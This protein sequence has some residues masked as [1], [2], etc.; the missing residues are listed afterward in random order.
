MSRIRSLLLLSIV[1]AVC[2]VCSGAAHGN[3]R[4]G[5]AGHAHSL[6]RHA[7]SVTAFEKEVLWTLETL[8]G[9]DRFALYR[10]YNHLMSAWAQ[11]AVSQALLEL[12]IAS[13]WP[14]DEQ[15]LRMTLR[16]QAQFALQDLDETRQGLE[17]DMLDIA[18]ADHRRI[19]EAARSLLVEM[20]VTLD[21]LLDDQCVPL[22]CTVGR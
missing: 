2:A 12:S 10:T 1:C 14:P 3:E 18:R 7:Q 16:D 22:R 5:D 6:A 19:N 20:R 13:T 8:P 4:V 21:R 9:D 17:R 15:A 11:V